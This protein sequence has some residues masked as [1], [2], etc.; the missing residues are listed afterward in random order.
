MAG[1]SRQRPEKCRQ[2]GLMPAPARQCQLE[3]GPA[4]RSL[5]VRTLSQDLQAGKLV[6]K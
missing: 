4:W 5:S 2:M 6:I 1:I 3:D